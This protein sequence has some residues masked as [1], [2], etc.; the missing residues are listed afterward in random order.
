LGSFTGSWV[1][2][3][4]FDATGSYDLMWIA[5][6]GAGLFAAAVHL[7]ISGKQVGEAKT[8]TA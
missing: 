4:M 5:V 6:I 8:A 7:P 1:G 3:I 2:G